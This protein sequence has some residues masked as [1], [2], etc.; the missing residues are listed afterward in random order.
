MNYNDIVTKL[1]YTAVIREKLLSFD[2][3]QINNL[4]QA[5]AE[6][7]E[8]ADADFPILRYSPVEKLV[9]MNLVLAEAYEGYR[10]L[11]VSDDIIID[12]FNDVALRASL[13]CTENGEI[14]I[15][16]DDAVWFRH[17]KNV[18][19]FKLGAVQF[20]PFKMIYLDMEGIGED[21]MRF[22]EEQKKQLPSG[23]PVI[24]CHIQKGQLFS[25]E[26]IGQSFEIAA[27]FMK[28]TFPDT[29]YKAF[30]CYS[31]LLYP[32]MT[33]LLAPESNIRFF[34]SLFEI[35]GECNDIEQAGEN[36]KEGTRLSN[37]FKSN[38]ERFGYACGI[39]YI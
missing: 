28:R 39:R 22:G 12:T 8:A 32:E 21:Y 29:A 37:A 15:S 10:K 25:H 31:W 18:M 14:G 7:Y 11:N 9:I 1:D 30:L 20:Q 27:S 13:F 16:D 34:A 26:S 6:A 33:S 24:N 3:E 38:P 19:I 2:M 5:A 35:I 17:I 4:K 23:T 36:I